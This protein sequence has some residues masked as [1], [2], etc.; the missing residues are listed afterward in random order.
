MANTIADH[1]Q[2]SDW[3]WNK[4]RWPSTR[5]KRHGNTSWNF[6]QTLKCKT[7]T[8]KAQWAFLSLFCLISEESGSR[9]FSCMAWPRTSGFRNRV[10]RPCSHQVLAWVF[11]LIHAKLAATAGSLRGL[12]CETIILIRQLANLWTIEAVV[13][14][15][16]SSKLSR[17]TS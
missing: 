2:I 10:W 17:N 12:H 3:I 1:L 13:C 9:N 4:T 5:K 7:K 16:Q 11:T 8:H 6:S 14:P 15:A